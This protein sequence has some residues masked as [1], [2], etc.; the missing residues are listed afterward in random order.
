MNYSAVS[1]TTTTSNFETVWGNKQRGQS[2]KQKRK[3]KKVGKNQ[4]N[5]WSDRCWLDVT[6][7]LVMLISSRKRQVTDEG[8]EKRKG[9]STEKLEREKGADHGNWLTKG[10]LRDNYLSVLPN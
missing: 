5:R 8:E 9:D 2:V 3:E 10:A 6:K 4:S 7:W 1:T